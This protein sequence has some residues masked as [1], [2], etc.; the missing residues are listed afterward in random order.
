MSRIPEKK[1]KDQKTTEKSLLSSMITGLAVAYAITSIVFIAYGIILTYTWASEKHISMVA[2]LTTLVSA[3]FA[4]FEGAGGAKERGLLWGLASG[5][6]YALILFVIG[7]FAHGGF[8][9][10]AGKLITMAV[11]LAAGGIGGIIGINSKK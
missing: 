8:T 2:L 3:A 10:D 5:G 6:L 7:F 11:S 9:P 1:K 4:G